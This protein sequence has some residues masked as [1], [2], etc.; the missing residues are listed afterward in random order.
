MFL[1]D[2]RY[3]ESLGYSSSSALSPSSPTRFAAPGSTLGAKN[4]TLVLPSV[5]ILARLVGLTSCVLHTKNKKVKSSVF[6][7]ENVTCTPPVCSVPIS[8]PSDGAVQGSTRYR[9]VRAV[10]SWV[11]TRPRVL[12]LSAIFCFLL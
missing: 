9:T 7:T 1:F 6:I 4:I 3:I 2:E 12:L 5:L 10:G 11:R 8:D